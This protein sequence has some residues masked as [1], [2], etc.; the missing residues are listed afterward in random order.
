MKLAETSAV[1]SQPPV[2]YGANFPL[3][4][5]GPVYK[6]P[7]TIASVAALVA[8]WVIWAVKWDYCCCYL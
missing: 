1:K 8:V 7:H 3:C 5:I 6:F 2:P 4:S